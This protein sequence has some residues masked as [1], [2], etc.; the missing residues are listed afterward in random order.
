MCVTACVRVRT[1]LPSPPP[2]ARA[3]HSD[4][5]KYVLNRPLVITGGST[6]THLDMS[7]IPEVV[8]LGVGINLTFQNISLKNVR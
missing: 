5:N 2:L 8:V 3:L 4:E 1:S 7:F 6:S